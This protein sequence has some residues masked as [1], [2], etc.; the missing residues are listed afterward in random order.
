MTAT[1][2]PST[3]EVEGQHTAVVCTQTLD[4]VTWMDS[5]TPDR[6]Y[7][8]CTCGYDGP[9]RRHFG[10]AVDD[11]AAHLAAVRAAA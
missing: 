6:H 10:L 4:P 3:A 8:A 7:L 11:K 9:M 1:I 2:D 5:S